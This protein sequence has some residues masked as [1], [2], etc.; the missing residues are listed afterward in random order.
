VL[1]NHHGVSYETPVSR[2][3]MLSCVTDPRE[4]TA[5]IDAKT[6]SS[7]VVQEE[8]SRLKEEVAEDIGK[9]EKAWQW[10]KFMN[11]KPV[12]KN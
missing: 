10:K 9:G 5:S 1:F 3:M 11:M 6:W 7:Q 4:V 2:K 12:T 8:Y